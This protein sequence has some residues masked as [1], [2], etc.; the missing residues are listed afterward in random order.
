MDLRLL[1]TANTTKLHSLQ[2]PSGHVTHHTIILL[3][4]SLYREKKKL[5]FQVFALNHVIASNVQTN[6][7]VWNCIKYHN[8]S[9][10]NIVAYFTA[11]FT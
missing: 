2:Y 3:F 4:L 11:I 1:V 10:K 7:C 9:G 6:A 8:N 5:F